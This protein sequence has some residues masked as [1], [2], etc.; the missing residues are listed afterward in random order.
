MTG[1][2][3]ALS[4]NILDSLPDAIFVIDLKHRVIVWNKSMEDITGVSREQAIGQGAYF[5]SLFFY[6]QVGPMLADLVINPA[7]EE[8]YRNPFRR[9]GKNIYSEEFITRK[10]SGNELYYSTKASPIFDKQGRIVAAIEILSDI[11]SIK[12]L[13]FYSQAANQQAEAAFQQLMAVEEELRQQYEELENTARQLRKQL[14]Y[15]NT[16]V[17]NLNELFYTFDQDIRLTFINKKS[18]DVL[19]YRPEELI[20]TF[21][22]ADIFPDED[23][24]WIEKE[25]RKRLA[26]GSSSSYVLPVRHKDGSKKYVKINSAAIMEEGRVVGGMVLA[27][28]ITENIKASEALRESESNLRRITDN[29]LDLVS[30]L[31]VRGNL[32]FAS[33]SH[34]KVLGYAAEAMANIKISDFV[35]PDDLSGVLYALKNILDTGAVGTSQHRC[36]HAEGHYIWTETVGNPIAQNGIVSGVILS[37]RDITERKQLEQELRYLSVHDSLTN[38]YNRT[39]FEEEM[40]RLDSGRINPVGMMIFDLD[41]LK[42]VNDT[43]GHEAGDRLLIKTAD[44]LRSCFRYGDVISRVGGDEFAVLFPNAERRVLEEAATRIQT[45]INDYNQNSPQLPLSL[46]IG[47]AV[48]KEGSLSLR[49]TYK[50]ADNNMYRIKLQSSRSARSAVVQTLLKALEARDFITE[51]HGERMQSLAVLLGRELGLA[52]TTITTLQLLAQFHDIGKVGVPDRILFKEGR[53]TQEEYQEMQ[54]HC[55]IGQR[56]ALASPELSSLAELILKHHE[57][58]NGKGYPLGLEGEKIPLECRI[59]ALADAYDAMTNDRPYRPA[60]LVNEAKAEI[61]RCSGTQFEPMLAKKFLELLSVY[62]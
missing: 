30:E 40:S 26:T 47:M 33:P 44:I 28:D 17:D 25:I 38:L 52:D 15:T 35:H 42:L 56:I 41:G 20:G 22:T 6:G 57:W 21:R 9:E 4:S 18:M 14:D 53:L 50:E 23:W 61:I 39:Y 2:N 51:G 13:D 62:E 10:E 54:R 32:V 1:L 46:S 31:D 24:E 11:S 8:N 7:L 60:M 58:W 45:M 27:D 29:M 36:K 12:A 49:E 34:Y 48:R 3:P 19:G 59:I 16:M 55:E 43:L 5:Y 37:S